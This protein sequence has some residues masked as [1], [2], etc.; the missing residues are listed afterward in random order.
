MTEL[1]FSQFWRLRSVRP[2]HSQNWFHSEA[3]PLYLQ[4]EAIFLFVLI[5]PLP[6]VCILRKRERSLVYLL[7]RTTILL[8]RDPTLMT[9]FNLNYFCRDSYIQIDTTLEVRA[10]PYISIW[11]RI[12]NIHGRIHVLQYI[13][14]IH[15][16]PTYPI[17]SKV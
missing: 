16:I 9:S 7:L 2:R 6:S 17:N 10:L 13:K 1:Y 15:S 3:S 11:G 12:I 14:Y 4:V 8:D 5:G